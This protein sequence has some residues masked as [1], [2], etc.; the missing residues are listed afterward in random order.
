M[1]RR[2]EMRSYLLLLVF[3]S[4]VSSGIADAPQVVESRDVDAGSIK[5]RFV[6]VSRIGDKVHFVS[7]HLA[8]KVEGNS[9]FVHE[10]TVAVGDGIT[11]PDHHIRMTIVIKAIS[12]TGVRIDYDDRF[13][14]RSFSINQIR[15]DAGSIEIPWFQ[16][17]PSNL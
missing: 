8:M 5:Q 14:Q 4:T 6:S 10:V 9:E 2:K 15:H 11:F 3:L 1:R 17:P 7:K 12:K 13:D 16:A